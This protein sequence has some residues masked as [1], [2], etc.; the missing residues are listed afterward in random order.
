VTVASLTWLVYD[1]V[2]TADAEVTP[3]YTG[4]YGI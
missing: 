2:L 1:M 3:T 4:I